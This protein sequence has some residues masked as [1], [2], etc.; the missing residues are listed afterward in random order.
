MLEFEIPPLTFQM[1]TTPYEYI[2]AGR[3]VTIDNYNKAFPNIKNY[4]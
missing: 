1:V 4:Y 2:H 3:Q